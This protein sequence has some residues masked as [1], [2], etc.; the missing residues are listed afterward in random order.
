MNDGASPDLP[1]GR[2][3]VPSGVPGQATLRIQDSNMRDVVSQ[4]LPP[5]KRLIPSRGHYCKADLAPR[6]WR[7]AD[8]CVADCKAEF[9]VAEN[10][11]S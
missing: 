2:L 5:E 10:L 8:M 4:R 1:G 11:I 3:R 6:G 7:H 9:F